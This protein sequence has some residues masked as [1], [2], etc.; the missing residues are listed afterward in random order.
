MPAISPDGFG[1]RKYECPAPLFRHNGGQ[2]DPSCREYLLWPTADN[3]RHRRLTR[4]DGLDEAFLGF[5]SRGFGPAIAVAYSADAVFRILTAG[6]ILTRA[7]FPAV[8]AADAVEF[9]RG[10]L[11]GVW[12]GDRTP[13][14]V[15]A[16]PSWE[17]LVAQNAPLFV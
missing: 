9:V 13:F 6:D 8:D 10:N 11:L 5:V 7:W 4:W 2:P 16:T 12:M 3:G 17:D 1:W 15:S 14:L